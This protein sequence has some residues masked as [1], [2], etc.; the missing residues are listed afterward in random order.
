[1]GVQLIGPAWEEHRLLRM[2]QMFQSAT[3]F[4]EQ[5]PPL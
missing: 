5:T 3:D 2:A 4:H 1:V